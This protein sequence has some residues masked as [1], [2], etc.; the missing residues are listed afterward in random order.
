MTDN[1]ARGVL[2]H[3]PLRPRKLWELPAGTAHWLRAWPKPPHDDTKSIS[4]G[5]PSAKLYHTRP[6]GLWISCSQERLADI[7]AVEHCSSMQNLGD[8]RSRY[9][10]STNSII[11]FL[12]WKWLHGHITAKLRRHTYLGFQREPSED[13]ALP[14]R[15]L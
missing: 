7:F 12:P 1:E 14:V 6:D 15:H 3:W 13:A 9:I 4:L 11:A 5:P 2:Q 10:A 8:K